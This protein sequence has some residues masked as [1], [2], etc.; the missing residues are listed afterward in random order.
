MMRVTP[1]GW[2]RP[3]I[4]LL[5]LAGTS[6]DDDPDRSV[7]VNEIDNGYLVR[8]RIKPI[9]G[10]C[11]APAM[12]LF[13]G[14]LSLSG[15][16]RRNTWTVIRSNVKDIENMNIELAFERRKITRSGLHLVIPR[17][18]VQQRPFTFQFNAFPCNASRKSTDLKGGIYSVVVVADLAPYYIAPR[19]HE[20]SPMDKEAMP[21]ST[22]DPS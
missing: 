6:C 15:Y 8:M 18:E 21:S 13:D 12:I 9:E 14:N 22:F 11:Y 19:V 2:L 7:R 4:I 1:P 17:N 20:P 5:S 10:L 16:D 3:F